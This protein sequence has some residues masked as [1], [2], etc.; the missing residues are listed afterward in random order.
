LRVFPRQ[1]DA[2]VASL[3]TPHADVVGEPTGEARRVY[4]SGSPGLAI[5][6]M[7]FSWA[8]AILTTYREFPKGRLPV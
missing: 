7:P 5:G 1:L 2:H 8:V 6:N 3:V 4:D